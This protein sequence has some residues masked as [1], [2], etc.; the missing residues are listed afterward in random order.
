MEAM[1]QGESEA[2]KPLDP[3]PGVYR[4]RDG[5]LYH[6]LMVG[7]DSTNPPDGSQASHEP[8]VIYVPLGKWKGRVKVRSLKQ[9]SE[10]VTW[11]DGVNRP[12]FNLVDL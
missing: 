12:R 9:W 1:L 4:H 7:D 3:V 5:D 11:P 2:K 8:V 6:L 10:M